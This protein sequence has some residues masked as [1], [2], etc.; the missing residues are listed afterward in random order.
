MRVTFVGG[1]LCRTS[2][3]LLDMECQCVGK[4]LYRKLER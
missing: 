1:T 2:K 3:L 4:N